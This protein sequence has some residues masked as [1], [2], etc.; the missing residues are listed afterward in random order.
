MRT[1]AFKLDEH[2]IDVSFTET[3]LHIT[4]ADGRELSVPLEWFPRL[5]DATEQE[6]NNWELLGNG[7]GIHWPSVDEDISI[8]MLIH[9]RD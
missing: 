5:R 8:S 2:A 3:A 6:R 7:V 1:S 9:G 4:L